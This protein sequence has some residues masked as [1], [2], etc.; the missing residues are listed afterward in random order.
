MLIVVVAATVM[1]AAVAVV[2][3]VVPAAVVS[4]VAA[5]VPVSVGELPKRQLMKKKLE[6]DVEKSFN[7]NLSKVF[8]R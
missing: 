2:L 5:A 8:S 6:Q 7:N 3:V 4:E 1:V